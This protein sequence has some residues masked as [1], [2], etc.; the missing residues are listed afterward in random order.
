MTNQLGK[1][2]I[3]EQYFKAAVKTFLHFHIL[4][5]AQKN[6]FEYIPTFSNYHFLFFEFSF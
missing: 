4:I 1:N 5:N 3:Q 2:G 6:N